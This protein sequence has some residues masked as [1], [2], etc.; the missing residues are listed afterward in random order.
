LWIPTIW[1]LIQGSR[2]LDTWFDGLSSTNSQDGSVLDRWVLTTLILSSLC[3]LARRRVRWSR[4]L[5]NNTPLVSIC[6]LAG[7]SILWS[8]FPL[9]SLKRWIR[10]I[11]II[12]IAALVQSE[13]SPLHAM[14][15]VLRRC[16]YI[17]IPISL[18]LIKYY[19]TYGRDYGRWSGALSWSGVTL[20]KNALGHLC[21]ISVLFLVWELIQATE[22]RGFSIRLPQ[23][24]D[25]LVLATASVML[26][27]IG[28]GRGPA[29]G[30]HSATSTAVVLGSLVAMYCLYKL[31]KAA[32]RGARLL[33]CAIVFI[34]LSFIFL[35]SVRGAITSALG[36]DETFTG[37]TAI[38]EV[39]LDAA[40]QHPVWGAGYGG[41]FGTPGN[42]L[43]QK[44]RVIQ[45]HNGLL[46]VY[47]ELGIIGVILVI[48]FHLHLYQR[49]S[50]ELARHRDW[51]VLSICLLTAS[52][53]SNFSESIFLNSQSYIWNITMLLA[54]VAP[55]TVGKRS[56]SP[57]PITRS[58]TSES[59]LNAVI[60]LPAANGHTDIW[61]SSQ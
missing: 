51:A 21:M 60:P 58:I 45:G 15:S 39:C 50:R 11:G 19:P 23:L 3:I 59:I 30:G 40:A 43:F 14:E 20:T 22:R 27:G 34:W 41:Y 17:L 10:L 57:A 1:L 49:W 8:H 52:L 6:L 42:E 16:A 55:L 4:I 36:R 47:V 7:A 13:R 37:R 46:S 61:K 33:M 9:L 5:K 28:I 31:K 25:G 18:V 38:W 26:F 56:Y 2:P 54:C 24:A 53:L 29:V 35:Q 12:P 44:Y 48:W 32:R